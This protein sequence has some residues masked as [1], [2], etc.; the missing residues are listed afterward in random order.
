MQRNIS[1][2]VTS[3]E[4]SE[5]PLDES[6]FV[7]H[8]FNSKHRNFHFPNAEIG[9]KWISRNAPPTYTPAMKRKVDA[10]LVFMCSYFEHG[11]C[12]WFLK[13]EGTAGVEYDWDGVRNAGLLVCTMNARERKGRDI[14]QEARDLLELYT[15]YCNGSFLYARI[16]D[17]DTGEVI[18][19]CGGILELESFL[20]DHADLLASADIT[21]ADRDGF[22][23]TMRSAVRSVLAKHKE[24]AKLVPA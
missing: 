1:I 8:S 14:Q 4:D 22:E 21:Y 19:S 11:Q 6:G 5:N 3:D 13:G 7:L 23:S 9:I 16:D 10:G 17:D 20:S 24:S 18:D 12:S 2:T 15:H